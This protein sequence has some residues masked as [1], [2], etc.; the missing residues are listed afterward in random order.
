MKYFITTTLILISVFSMTSCTS[1]KNA[2][3]QVKS[4][5]EESYSIKPEV[6]AANANTYIKITSNNITSSSLTLSIY[7]DNDLFINET[8][9]PTSKST[10]SYS[11][12]IPKSSH[13]LKV[14]IDDIDRFNIPFNN[15]SK[16]QLVTINYDNKNPISEVT[17]TVVDA[18]TK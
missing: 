15:S 1:N 18:P 14:Y 3:P 6:A 12:R 9:N 7:I 10:L 11:Y 13:L 4:P 16:E 2:A 8:L 17:A 5:I